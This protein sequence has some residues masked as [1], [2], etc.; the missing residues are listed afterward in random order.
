M[1]A[2]GYALGEEAVDAFAALPAKQRQKVLRFCGHLAR[3]P[4]LAGDYREL[5][6]TGRTYE[7]KLIEEL[8]VTWWVDHAER[9][10]RIVRLERIE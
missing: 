9:E 3:F 1:T 8:L 10:V 6:Q 2:Y 5:G 4:K 7:L